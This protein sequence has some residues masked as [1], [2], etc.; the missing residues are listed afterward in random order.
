MTQPLFLTVASNT[1]APALATLQQLGYTVTYSS[2]GYRANSAARSLLAEDLVQ[3][4]GLVL[5]LD[6]RGDAWQPSDDEVEKL[7]ELHEGA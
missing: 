5:L 3:L 1:L 7:L 2:A 6:V 4:L